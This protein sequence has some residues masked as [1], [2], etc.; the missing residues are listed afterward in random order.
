MPEN[1]LNEFHVSFPQYYP[2]LNSIR[3]QMPI[4]PYCGFF[5]NQN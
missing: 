3:E 2:T 4:Y 1:F 5:R